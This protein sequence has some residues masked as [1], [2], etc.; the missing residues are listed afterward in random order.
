MKQ[1]RERIA[2]TMRGIES[3]IWRNKT[4]G[5]SSKVKN[6]LLIK[7]EEKIELDIFFRSKNNESSSY[8]VF[9]VE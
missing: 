7:I 5:L 4:L 8:G 3:G 1:V 9:S 2:N 6:K